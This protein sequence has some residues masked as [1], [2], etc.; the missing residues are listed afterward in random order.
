MSEN[1]QFCSYHTKRDVL[2]KVVSQR[3]LK[4]KNL[5]NNQFPIP[6]HMSL[7]LS[8]IPSWVAQ[9]PGSTDLIVIRLMDMPVT[10]Q[11][12]VCVA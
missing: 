6:P 1:Y 12:D 10:P 5:I 3:F 4:Q 8:L 7:S 11:P 2:P 9:D